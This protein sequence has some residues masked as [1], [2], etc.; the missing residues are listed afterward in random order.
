MLSHYPAVS[1]PLDN[2]DVIKKLH[3][4]M[5]HPGSSCLREYLLPYHDISVNE[6]LKVTNHCKVCAEVKPQFFRSPLGKLIHATA[7]WQWVSIDLVG[8]KASKTANHYLFTVIDEYSR[9][10]FVFPLRSQSLQTVMSCLSSL[11]YL[12]GAPL[13]MHSDRGAQFESQCF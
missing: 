8:P 11:F 6:I 9:Y 2:H 1:Y 7:P 3:V 12:F 5:G 10:P 13:N 4:S